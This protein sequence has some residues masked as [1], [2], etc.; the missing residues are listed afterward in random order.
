MVE[1]KKKIY[2]VVTQEDIE[3]GIPAWS[4]KCPVALAISR[5]VDGYITVG[6]G[7]MN[8]SAPS[9]DFYSSPLPERAQKFIE[10][11]DMGNKVYPIR[12]PITLR[13]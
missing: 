12:F 8:V 2:V 7:R 6:G 9:S 3:E 13:D 11:F 1:K 10:D 4:S 5:E